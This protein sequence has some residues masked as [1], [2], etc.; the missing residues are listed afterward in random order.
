MN[1]K[2]KEGTCCNEIYIS[3]KKSFNA[4]KYDND[5]ANSAWKER[6]AENAAAM[7]RITWQ[8]PVRMLVH[9]DLM[10]QL[11]ADQNSGMK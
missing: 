3:K 6:W 4:R 10:L 1:E 2:R 9:A 8:R 11:P 7:A 5:G